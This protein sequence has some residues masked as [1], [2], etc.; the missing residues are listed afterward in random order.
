[1]YGLPSDFDPDIFV[2][3][4]LETISF[5]V[6]V[7]VLAFANR[8]TVS[9]SGSLPYRAPGEKEMAV[10]RPP[11]AQTSL[12]SLVGRRVVTCELK[13]SREL[14]LRFEGDGSLTLLD[15]SETYESY[16]VSTGDR[17]IIV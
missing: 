16:I 7:V 17:E 8:L 3:R 1:M 13:S 12:V 11:V 4:E 6:N 5:A 2:G 10:N 15:D 14:I 9:V